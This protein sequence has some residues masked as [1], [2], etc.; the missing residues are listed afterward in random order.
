V[1][2]SFKHADS[3][4]RPTA[5]SRLALSVRD[6][7]AEIGISVFVSSVEL[8]RTGRAD[9]KQAIDEALDS[10]RVL[11]AV[12]TSLENLS[13]RW[14]RYEWDT[15]LHDILDGRKPHG[16]MLTYIDSVRIQ[17]LPRTLRSV[18]AFYHGGS[19]LTRLR[20]VVR[21]ALLAGSEPPA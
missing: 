7:L 3:A 17:D 19:S 12:G 2:V 9:C 16:Q 5:D 6:S 20:E 1:F 4:G 21:N 14:V 8:E 10:A 15:F 18:Q 11:V 13:S